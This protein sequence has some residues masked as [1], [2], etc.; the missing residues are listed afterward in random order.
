MRQTL[1][2]AALAAIVTAA[3]ATTATAQNFPSRPVTLIV[4]FPAGG[5]TDINLRAL[6]TATEKHLGQSIVIE[7]R[8]GAGG[9]LG[10][11]QMAAHAKPDGYTIAQLPITVFRYPFMTKTAFD[12]AKDFTYIISL[13]GYTFGVVVRADAP[14]RTFKELIADAK[15]NPGKINYGTPGAGTSLHITMEQIAKRQGIQ[16]THVP[17]KGNAESN[18]ALLGGHINVVADSTG[19]GELV[20]A[21]KFRLL[22]TW[23]AA[24]TRNWPNVPTLRETG[25]DMISNSP[26]G[27][28][29]PAGMDAAVVKRLHDAFKQGMEAPSY[30]AVLAKLDQEPFYLNSADYRAFALKQ[31]EEQREL[32]KMLGLKV[33]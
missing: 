10:P 3:A 16:W 31:I 32:V 4:P 1:I 30:A 12:P 25:I 18:S 8:S 13:T 29:G 2:R 15:A 17:F 21:G 27:L 26:F 24:R 7:N 28:G 19:W 11:G 6:A 20:N 22:V 9:T 14:W 23:G 5:S 33:N